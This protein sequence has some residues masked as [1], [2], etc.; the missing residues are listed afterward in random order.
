MRRV[1]VTGMACACGDAQE[2]ETFFS[3][4]CEKKMFLKKVKKDKKSSENIHLTYCVPF[5]EIHGDAFKNELK[6]V[7]K[8]GNP[9]SYL[10]AYC[11]LE[12]LKES[13]LEKAEEDTS[14]Y[15]GM[16]VPSISSIEESVVEFGATGKMNMLSL[17][18]SMQNAAASW[19]SIV[20]GAHGRTQEIGAACASGTMSIGQGY[21]DIIS[22]RSDTALCGG[23]DCIADE[24]GIIIKGF[25]YLK[26]VSS[27]PSGESY[28][29][30]KE[31]CGF[32]LSEGAAA[33]LVLEELEHAKRRNAHILAEI[34]GFEC[35]SDAYSVVSM[36]ED[37]IYVEKMLRRLIG[38]KKID[39]Y[40]AHATGTILND[41]VEANVIRNIFGERDVQPAISATK[42][43]VG[44]SFGASGALEAIVCVDSIQNGKVHGS[45][46]KTIMDEINI[47]SETIDKN[48]E[49]AVSASF[50][51][52][53]LNAALMIKK[54][55]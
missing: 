29:F 41:A 34:T 43:I 21:L 40:N 7:K 39:Y 20:T 1:V 30:S 53:G 6:V 19:V 32:M 16:G 33:I 27:V 10:A 48:I 23:T 26:A 4:L 35:T 51:F 9:S 31:R 44:H 47:C 55:Q 13:G 45:N 42:S 14:V 38:D 28:P 18:M 8:R 22:G 3:N 52:G 37:G 24:Y 50:G 12:A 15:I 25:E 54:Y 36:P 11:A 5:P 2:H 17:P 49:T 46:C